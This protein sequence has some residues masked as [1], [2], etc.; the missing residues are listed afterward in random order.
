MTDALNLRR[1]ECV[2]FLRDDLYRLADGE[3][4]GGEYDC[5]KKWI[6]MNPPRTRFVVLEVLH[7]RS[8]TGAV[9]DAEGKALSITSGADPQWLDEVLP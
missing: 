9:L 7:E 5:S 3:H 1:R 6:Y 2:Q 4:P 8:L